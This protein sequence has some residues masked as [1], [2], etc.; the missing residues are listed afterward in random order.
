MLLIEAGI[1]EVVFTSSHPIGRSNSSLVRTDSRREPATFLKWNDSS[2]RGPFPKGWPRSFRERVKYL[3]NMFELEARDSEIA[4]HSSTSQQD[5]SLDIVCRVRVSDELEAV[6]YL[7][8]QCATGANWSTQKHSQPTMQLWDKYISWNGPRLK[9]LAVPF[10]LRDKGELTD[11]SVRHLDALVL[12]RQ[13]L[14]GSVPD[15]L[16]DD[17][18]R[19]DLTDWCSKKFSTFSMSTPVSRAHVKRKTQRK[20]AKVSA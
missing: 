3:A 16:I 5:D 9:A 11:A 15:D 19:Q 20:R 7:L 14:A 6:P 17:E 1:S 18:L 12:D 2:F 13:R 4:R 10:S 8:V